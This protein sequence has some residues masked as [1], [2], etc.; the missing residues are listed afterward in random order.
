MLVLGNILSQIEAHGSL[1]EF[2]INIFKYVTK[3]G[4]DIMAYCIVCSLCGG[5]DGVSCKKLKRKW[6]RFRFVAL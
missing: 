1:I 2:M 4:L 6:S 5:I 3:I